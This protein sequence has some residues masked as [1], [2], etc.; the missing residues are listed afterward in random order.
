MDD[1]V[2]FAA[3]QKALSIVGVS[4]SMQWDVFRILAGLLHIGNIH[5]IDN[6][7][8]AD[9][10]DSDPALLTA[11]RLLSIDTASFKKWLIKKQIST[12]SETVL[13]DADYKSANVSRDSVA[14]YIYT[15]LFDWIVQIVN[16]KLSPPT[17]SK[18]QTFIG[19]LDIYGFEHF[20]SNSFEQFCINYANEKLQQEFT[21]HVF[22]LE[23]EEYVAE[24]IEWS[25]ID[26]SDNGPC[27]DLIEAKLG[28]LDLLD[29]ET[30]LPSG[31]D[32]NLVT[33]L[34][35]R[36]SPPNGQGQGS[37]SKFFE[38]PRFAG[39]EFIIRHYA[40]NVTYQITGFLE[41]N[42][43]TVSDEIL[44]TLNASGF[45]FL[46]DVITVPLI[47]VG[48]PVEKTPTMG[49]AGRAPKKPTLGS[50]FKGS[51][52]KLME[53]IRSTNPHYIRCIKPNQAKVAFEF[54]PQNVLGQ[55]IACGVL[56]TIKISRAGYPS[57]LVYEEFVDRYYFL[58]KSSEW[59]QPPKDLSK[60]ICQKHVKGERKYELGTTKIFFRAGQLAFLE[61]IRSETF[62]RYIILI[63]KN[64]RKFIAMNHYVKL[65][66]GALV[67]QRLWRG[68]VA[69][70]QAWELRCTHSA[71]V[72]QRNIRRWII[73]KKYIK[74]RSGVC[75]IQ[76]AYRRH[77]R[78]A[79]AE[80]YESFDAAVLIQKTWRG[81]I[82]RKKCK[83]AVK[84]IIWMQSCVR[85]KRC[86]LRYKIMKVEAKTSGNLQQVNYK[87]EA[88]IVELSQKI[89]AKESE[90]VELVGK[91]NA[92]ENNVNSWKEKYVKLETEAKELS[93][94]ESD[95]TNELMKRI[96]QLLAENQ[97][98]QKENDKANAMVQ[99]R[100][101]QLSQLSAEIEKKDNE[102]VQLNAT[103][104]KAK[105]EKAT[106][107]LKKEIASLREQMSR[108]VAGK[109]AVDK[110]TEHFLN[111]DYKAAQK[112]DAD[113]SSS[114]FESAGLGIQQM[115]ENWIG[116]SNRKG[117]SLAHSNSVYN[118]GARLEPEYSLPRN[119][120]I[121]ML[122]A[123]DLEDEVV[124]SLIKNLRIPLP[125]TQAVASRKEIF[126]PAHLIG[127]L[128]SQ[129]QEHQLIDR[130]STFSDLIMKNIHSLTMKFEDDYVSAFWLSNT[131][132]LICIVKTIRETIPAP[133]AA[134]QDDER[135][136]SVILARI[137]ASLE[138]LLFEIY[139]GWL[140]ELKKRLQTMIVPAV[141]ENQS[142]PG[143]ICKESGGLW[144][145][146]STR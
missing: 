132:E 80:Y 47:D 100:D 103:K 22:K 73:R 67:V 146:W 142:L 14:K 110:R 133:T 83:K 49:R 117:G 54:E 15:L 29:E 115:A 21:R 5:I 18:A 143:Y 69:R 66:R 86:R 52:V 8:I 131:C 48:S 24:K 108:M 31:T 23:Q 59:N 70:K 19:V 76:R 27:I 53:T 106:A 46:K 33:K 32:E 7:G 45:E 40:L 88:K 136:A 84:S 135:S 85:R 101:D 122:E 30:R 62:G 120:P 109:Y 4:V 114:F 3:T 71:V 55:L 38:K 137:R 127:Y 113:K 41:K 96:Q 44:A 17:A 78:A 79:N 20:E 118:L 134:N 25:F 82:T 58:V 92:L 37:G 26:F 102:I 98:L 93:L 116:T 63:Q 68:K 99:K 90:N 128:I 125:S 138:L 35:N 81:Y 112:G 145:K 121:R 36:F 77:R 139:H 56:E 9:I 141:L 95:E 74:V 105:D 107:A 12:R 11:S 1:I 94:K 28:I 91:L 87:L 57:K 140:K 60:K 144:G 42:K 43:D 13:K 104:K 61:K 39:K 65:K 2:E 51:L 10:S 111:N 64:I 124:E 89:S 130:M 119:R 97:A 129:L 16:T 6:K 34:Y 72:I 126:F 50:I 123:K 75:K